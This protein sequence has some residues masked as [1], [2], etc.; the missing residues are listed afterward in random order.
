MVWLWFPFVAYIGLTSGIEGGQED[1]MAEMA[2]FPPM[3]YWEKIFARCVQF[4]PLP[5]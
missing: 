2:G 3:T 1:I 4:L 5:F